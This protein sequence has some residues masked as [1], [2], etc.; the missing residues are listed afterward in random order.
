[1]RAQ[2][3]LAG[4]RAAGPAAAV[5]G[6]ADGGHDGTRLVLEQPFEV[7]GLGEEVKSQLDKAGAALGSLLDFEL[8]HLVT[9]PADDDAESLG[10]AKELDRFGFFGHGCRR[11]ERVKR[12]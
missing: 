6:P 1:A 3:G 9:S 7:G 12:Y 11:P 10:G 8:D 4:V 5:V 2:Q